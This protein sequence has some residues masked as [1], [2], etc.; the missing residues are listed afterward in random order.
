MAIGTSRIA[1]PSVM[2][3]AL[4]LAGATTLVG[5]T[6]NTITPGKTCCGP[7]PSAS[8]GGAFGTIPAPATGA[9]H[10]GTIT[11]AESP[12]TAPTWILPLVTSAAYSV[13]DTTQ[14]SYEL[15]RPLYWFSNGV[16]PTQTPSMSLANAPVWSNGDTTATITLKSNYKWSDGQP[17]TSRDVL[18]FF[19]EVKAA[20]NEDP[21]NWGPYSPGLGIPDE[22]ASVTT[23]NASTVVFTMKKPVNPE[24]FYDNELPAVFPM[25][26]HAWAK[27]SASGP[28]LD[29]TVP[30]N[31][32]KIYNFLSKE[33]MSLS[34]YATNPLW[35]VVDG[36]Y[37]LAAFDSSTGAFTMTP[38]PSYGGPHA[39][40]VSI[41]QAVPFT[42]DTAEF[43]AVRA[44]SIDIGYLPL[45]DIKQLKIVES[46]GY[47]V[48]GYP[49]FGFNYVTYNFADTTG[50]FNHIIAQLYIRQAIAHLEDEQGYIKAFFG[51]AGGPAYGPIPTVP[52]SPYTPADAVTDPYPF[53]VADAISLLKSHGWTINT[54]GTDTCAQAGTGPGECGAGIPAGT[55]LAWNLI[56]ESSPAFVGEQ[57]TALASEAAAAGITIH[58]QSSNYNYIIT[59]YDDPVPTGKPYI[60]KWA[61][62]DWG[63]FIDNTYPTQLGIFNGPGAENEGDYNNPEANALINASVNSG[64]PA[65]VKAEASFLTENQPGLFQ[66]NS[67][68]V[69]VW[70]DDISG[71]QAS[72]AS[73]T[74]YYLN[75]EYWWFT[76]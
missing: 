68:N 65:A 60:N 59:Y 72:F 61:M 25:P 15:W 48:F 16:E 63:G 39:A 19:D 3:A 70:K 75:A 58:L 1:R 57:V 51:G 67:D 27:A 45:D 4:A 46:G 18:F 50:D 43:D 5:C 13:N 44:G 21:A 38:N 23:P 29:F 28:P 47:D 30:A 22:V 35:R 37:L 32:T 9:Q 33:S 62:E 2:I 54:S 55:K 76:G 7:P 34:T 53:S 56:Y 66:P 12:G 71:V 20:V 64:N 73:L 36:P 8:L 11:W 10:A 31:A 42:S 52:Q 74:Q 6:S 41:L 69:V 49:S 26:A 14:F 40:K 17:I 24:W